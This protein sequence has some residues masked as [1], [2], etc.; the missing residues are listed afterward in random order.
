MFSQLMGSGLPD[1]TV[2]IG[3]EAVD[4]GWLGNLPTRDECAI[5]TPEF[6]VAG[7][8]F[9]DDIVFIFSHSHFIC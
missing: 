7:R 8:Y 9:H 6:Y 4:F 3:L 2:C 5:P 1:A